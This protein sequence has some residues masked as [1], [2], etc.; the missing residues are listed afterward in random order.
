METIVL[1]KKKNSDNP[2]PTGD[3]FFENS[4]DRAEVEARVKAHKAG[5]AKTAVSLHSAEEIKNFIN[6]L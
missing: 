6:N 5:K 4:D 2:S 3:P 1:E